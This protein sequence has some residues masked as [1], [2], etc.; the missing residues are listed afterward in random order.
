MDLSIIIVSWNTRELLRNCLRSIELCSSS[1]QVQTIVVDNNS[2]DGTREMVS[3]LFPWVF[4]LNSGGNLGFARAN[5]LGLPHACA[6]LVLYLNPD[7]EVRGESL[8]QMVEYMRRESS[9][10]ALG[11]KI[12]NLDG[13]VQ[14]LG[15]QWFPSPITEFLK[16]LVVSDHT[17]RRLAGVFP[18]HDPAASGE[19][20]KLYGACLMVRRSVL[21]QVGTFDERF[22]MYCEDVDFCHRISRAGWRIYYLASAEIMHL[23]G[24]SSASAPGSFPVL[25]MCESFSKLMS[26][27]YGWL[28]AVG[29]RFAALLGSQVRLVLL[30]CIR[31]LQ[32]LG[33]H[34]FASDI[35]GPTRKYWAVT[36]WSLGLDKPVARN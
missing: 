17:V 9:I 22:F 31:L 27:Y 13:S 29:Y 10:G 28:G 18:W 5:N 25:M 32:V 14:P 16:L 15:L 3:R 8:L 33:W 23:G 2:A 24:A 6:P 4:L 36:R 1:L 19:V 7:T 11:C 20:K 12:R 30:C 26:K 34:A 21:D 35:T